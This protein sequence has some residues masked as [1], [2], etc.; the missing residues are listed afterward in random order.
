[1]G[2]MGSTGYAVVPPSKLKTSIGRWVLTFVEDQS[3]L[4]RIWVRQGSRRS[5]CFKPVIEDTPWNSRH[6]VKQGHRGTDAASNL[7]I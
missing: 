1:M 4:Y 3:T 2:S 7:K 5:A 6:N